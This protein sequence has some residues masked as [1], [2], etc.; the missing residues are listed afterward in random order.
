MLPA[1]GTYYV[2]ILTNGVNAN[3]SLSLSFANPT[4]GTF[5]LTPRETTVHA[6]EHARLGLDW[7]VL[8]GVRWVFMTPLFPERL[9]EQFPRK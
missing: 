2:H 9:L 3:Y 6:E 8:A 7:T 5:A 4:A 1:A